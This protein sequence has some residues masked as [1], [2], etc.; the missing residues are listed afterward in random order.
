MI[1]NQPVMFVH[2]NKLVNKFHKAKSDKD[3]LGRIVEHYTRW[4]SLSLAVKSR[5][6]SSIIELV[7]YLNEYKDIVEPFFDSRKN[8]AQ[9]L[10][11]SSIIEEFFEYLF[12]NIEVEIGVD[13]YR[14]QAKSF[15]DIVFNPMTIRSLTELPDYT[16]RTKDH[17]FVIGGEIFLKFSSMKITE[18]RIEKI[19]IP[20]VAIECKRY[21]E[22]NMLDECSGTA[23]KVKRANPYCKY[24]VVSEFLK[25][26]DSRPELSSIDEIFILRKQKNSERKTGKINPIYADLIFE[27]YTDVVNHLKKMW[28]SPDTALVYGKV[29]NKI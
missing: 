23:E 7:K 29:F 20:A 17:D 18:E 12:C 27:L 11:Q 1:N 8:S 22:R 2:G 6:E 10:L 24:I 13:P 3:E 28:W 19:I 14:Q 9:E 15:V 21:L 4:K 16:I 5:D 26:D 25:L